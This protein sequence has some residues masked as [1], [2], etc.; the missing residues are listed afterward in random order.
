MGFHGASGG[1]RIAPAQGV[2]DHFVLGQR[3][4]LPSGRG[5]E[6][7]HAI[8]AGAGSLDGRLDAGKAE[9]VEE[10]LVEAEVERMEGAAVVGLDGVAL[11]S[12]V[13]VELCEEAAGVVAL[14]DAAPPRPRGRGG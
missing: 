14:K 2:D 9:P 1:R 5:Q 7:A 11:A 8:E 10:D 12:E 4:G 6:P 3:D 13:E